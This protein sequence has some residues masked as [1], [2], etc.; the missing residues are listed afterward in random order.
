MI[1][2]TSKSLHQHLRNFFRELS[3][4]TKV[5]NWLNNVSYFLLWWASMD[6][7]DIDRL[8]SQWG[9]CFQIKN[10]C[11]K[12]HRTYIQQFHIHLCET[13]DSYSIYNSN[14]ITK[15]I[16]GDIKW[17]SESCVTWRI[18]RMHLFS[19]FFISGNNNRRV[20]TCWTQCNPS[21]TCFN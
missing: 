1:N 12:G 2:F 18:R 21:R 17:F 13:E 4:V 14:W 10:A 9:N 6:L 20:V 16:N 8:W 11:F 3:T 15:L 7:V 19:I 5:D